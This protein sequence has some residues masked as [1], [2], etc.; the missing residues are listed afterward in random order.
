[1]TDAQADR[2]YYGT[3]LDEV[4]EDYAYEMSRQRKLDYF[5]EGAEQEW[6]DQRL[7]Y[8]KED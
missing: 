8:L 3:V 2:L 6:R 7:M 5:D 4:N 1:M